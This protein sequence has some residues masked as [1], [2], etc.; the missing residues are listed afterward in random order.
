MKF[1]CD[2]FNK[3]SAADRTTF[4]GEVNDALISGTPTLTREGEKRVLNA[5][6]KELFKASAKTPEAEELIIQ[7]MK[8]ADLNKYISR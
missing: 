8:E 1:P 6:G 5:E 7:Q 2:I 4:L 3:Q